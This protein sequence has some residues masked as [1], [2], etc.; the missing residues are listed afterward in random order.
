MTILC[1]TAQWPTSLQAAGP[2]QDPTILLRGPATVAGASYAVLAIRIDPVRM[3]PD[4]RDDVP[5]S[6]Y[7]Q[8]ELAEI[9]DALMS[10]TAITDEVLLPLDDGY[11]VFLM[12]PAGAD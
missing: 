8:T 6:A 3:A 5:A 7:A 9:M 10:W 11:Y 4:L 1:P 2:Q 12:L